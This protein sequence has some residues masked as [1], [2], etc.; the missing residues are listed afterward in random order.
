MSSAGKVKGTDGV[1]GFGA[2]T[3]AAQVKCFTWNSVST[4]E[5]KPR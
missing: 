2:H 3:L 4:E 5:E 1:G